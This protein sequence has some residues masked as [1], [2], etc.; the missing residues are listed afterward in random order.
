MAAL[1]PETHH[2]VDAAFLAK[3]PTHAVL[4]NVARGPIVDEEALI[5]ALEAGSIRAAGLDVFEN[6][7]QTSGVERLD[8]VTLAP[9]SLAWTSEMSLGNGGSC[10]QA[11]LDVLSGRAPRFLLNPD[12][13][14]HSNVVARAGSLA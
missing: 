8:N 4:I 5:A 11:V 3:M 7:P 10:V 14:G 12:V 2:L 9:H 13:L 1:T 6:E